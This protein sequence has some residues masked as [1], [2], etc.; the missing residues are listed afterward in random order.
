LLL[1]LVVAGCAPESRYR[2]LSLFLDGVPPPGAAVD[3]VRPGDF[4]TEGKSRLE[5]RRRAADAAGGGRPFAHGPYA[6]KN[7][8]ACHAGGSGATSMFIPGLSGTGRMPA[9]GPKLRL[10]RREI[11][12]YCHENFRAR[13]LNQSYAFTHG[14]VA[15]GACLRCHN[16]HI[17][18]NPYMIRKAPIRDLCLDCHDERDIYSRAY[19]VGE[20]QRDCTACHHP[21]GGD[22]RFFLLPQRPPPTSP[23]N[24]SP[25]AAPPASGSHM[26]GL[27]L[28]GGRG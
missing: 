16:P 19:H 23:A 10:P 4:L 9:F 24:G 11:C 25:P 1:T 6:S 14:P 7:C 12:M 20:G 22:N 18:P 2:V 8:P 21:H 13:E 26:A 28:A 27:G 5:R 17:S 15:A 3:E